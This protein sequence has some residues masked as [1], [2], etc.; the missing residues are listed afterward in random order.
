[1]KRRLIFSFVTVVLAINLLVGARL[2][3]SSAAAA[4]KDLPYP[5]MK[6]FADVMEKVRKD[7]VAGQDLTYQELVYGALQGMVDKLDPHR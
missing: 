3:V 5:N 2:Y 1:M 6:L 4:Q 7:Y